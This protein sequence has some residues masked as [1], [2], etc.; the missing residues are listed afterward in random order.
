MRELPRRMLELGI[1]AGQIQRGPTRHD[2][3]DDVSVGGPGRRR[4]AA[5]WAAAFALPGGGGGGTT[6]RPGAA[7]R[8]GP[9]KPRSSE[10][11]VRVPALLPAPDSAGPLEGP[12]LASAG[13]LLAGQGQAILKETV[14][15]EQRRPRV[16]EVTQV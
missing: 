10:S 16:R 4:R 13:V 12:P 11:R 3:E 7:R 8:D 1:S 15:S 14:M 2:L 9:R 6:A 5:L